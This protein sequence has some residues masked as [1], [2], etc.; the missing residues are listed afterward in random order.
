VIAPEGTDNPERLY[1]R[2]AQA[3]LAPMRQPL[4][5]VT[6]LML[7]GARIALQRRGFW[8]NQKYSNRKSLA[9]LIPM[10]TKKRASK[11]YRADR[12]KTAETKRVTEA[13]HTSCSPNYL[14]ALAEAVVAKRRR[15]LAPMPE[16]DAQKLVHQLQVHQVELEMQNEELHRTQSALEEARDRYVDLYD[17]APL[18]LVTLSPAGEVLEANLAAASLLGLD[19]KAL[20]HPKL[21]RFI[22]VESQDAFHLYCH[23]VLHSEVRQTGELTL[24]NATGGSLTVRLEG[25][26]A[27][28]P[29][30]RERHCRLSLTNITEHKETERR[31]DLT[32]ALAAL[33]A[34]KNSASEYLQAV[35]ELIRQWSGSEALGIRLVNDAQE[36][37]YESWAGFEPGFIDLESR[38]SLQ[39]DACCCIRAITQAVESP[40]RTLLT[41]GGSYRCDNLHAF[42]EQITPQ[43]RARYRGNCVKFGF[44]SVAVVPIHC[45]EGI[46]GAIHLADRRIGQF[47]PPVIEFVESLTPLIG[48]AIRRFQAEAELAKHRDHLEELV[49]QRTRELEAANEQLRTEVASRE[50]AEEALLHAAEALKRSNLDLEQFG[51]VASHDLQEPLRAVAGFVRLLEH[52]FPEKL[53]AKMREYIAGAA[54]GATRMERLITDLLTFSRLSTEGSAF[55]PANLAAP[56]NVALRNLQFS[57]LSANATVTIDPLPTASVDESQMAQLFQNLIANALKFRSEHAPQIHIGARSEEGR[58]VLWVRDNGIGIEPQYFE[59]IFQ[60]FQR[61]HT[62]NKYPGT[63]I[64]LAICKKIVERHGGQIWVES[65]PGLGS[66]FYFSLPGAP[67]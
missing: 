49:A 40:D 45:R 15:D 34:H 63:G 50:I 7:S 13:P 20:I 54:E 19:R 29:N 33:F 9:W 35:V 57:I 56:L 46:L 61:L 43:E 39:R 42:T 27:D 66:T 44:A 62:R 30:T 47:P 2:L 48:E 60:V 3:T 55:T 41:P 23:Q 32:S 53:D 17:F 10:A 24:K 21:T 67:R 52:R 25:I 51:Y 38:L 5:W 1:P 12:L 59:R 26:A 18:A 22:P 11:G 4:A 37:P 14:R 36:I 58:W 65:Q 6:P 28:D 8:R 16:P 31:R 64:G